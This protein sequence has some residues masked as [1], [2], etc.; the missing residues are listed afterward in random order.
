M[1]LNYAKCNYIAMN[2][3]AKIQFRNGEMMKEVDEAIY[4]GGTLTNEAG[5]MDELNRR[6]G[7]AL[8]TCNKLKTFWYK[9]RCSYK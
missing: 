9:T 6:F 2:G 4:L 7:I 3:K 5:R 8:Q 1:E